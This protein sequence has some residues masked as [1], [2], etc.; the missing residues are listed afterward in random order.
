[1]KD[2]NIQI[3][4]A[5][6]VIGAGASAG[7]LYSQPILN[8]LNLNPQANS[9][10]ASF[11]SNKTVISLANQTQSPPL[12]QP[13]MTLMG[14]NQYA[15]LHF[16]M[17]VNYNGSYQY[18]NIRFI[19][20]VWN[21]TG[22]SL[23]D[24]SNIPIDNATQPNFN[25]NFTIKPSINQAIFPNSN[26][27]Q[28][29]IVPTESSSLTSGDI[30]GQ[31]QDQLIASYFIS[32]QNKTESKLVILNWNNN[33]H[34]FTP[35]TSNISLGLYYPT[36]IAINLRGYG[37]EQILIAGY[38]SLNDSYITM[39][40]INFS[41]DGNPVNNGSKLTIITDILNNIQTTPG[42]L[43]LEK[44][45]VY[46]Y[47]SQQFLIYGTAQDGLKFLSLYGYNL[48]TD[49]VSYLSTLQGPN[50][51]RPLLTSFFNNG[52]SQLVVPCLTVCNANINDPTYPNFKGGFI[53]A[54]DIFNNTLVKYALFPYVGVV[55]AGNIN[56]AGADQIAL[57]Q[58]NTLALFSFNNSYMLYN[59]ANN[60]Y[61][62][63]PVELNQQGQMLWSNL[64][65]GTYSSQVTMPVIVSDI[66]FDSI[67]E[68]LAPDYN[69]GGVRFYLVR[70][71]SN[72]KDN[73]V[74]GNSTSI[75]TG[76]NLIDSLYT[77]TTGTIASHGTGNFTYYDLSNARTS[78]DLFGQAL[79]LIH[80]DTYL[81]PSNP[82]I[83]AVLAAAPTVSGISQDPT[84]AVTQY[85]VSTSSGSTSEVS[86][87]FGFDL[88]AGI[89]T[90][91]EISYGLGVETLG[92]EISYMAKFGFGMTFSSSYEHTKT[93][94]VA[95]TWGT[96]G[97][98]N[99]VVFASLLIKH[100]NY[101][102]V[103]GPM[104][105][106]NLTFS[107]PLAVTIQKFDINT[108]DQLFPQYN[109]QTGT[110][111]PI[112]K[113]GHPETYPAKSQ[114]SSITAGSPF[115][116]ESPQKGV[117]QGTG[118]DTV[119]IDV[120]SETSV[121]NSVDFHTTAG[122][123]FEIATEGF[124]ASLEYQESAAFGHSF[125]VS[126]G[127]GT[128]Y[129]GQITDINYYSDW[130]HYQFNYGMFAYLEN[131]TAS[132]VPISYQVINYWV[133]PLGPSFGSGAL[134]VLQL[135]T[136]NIAYHSQLMAV[137]SIFRPK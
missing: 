82:T 124:Q 55:G 68:I 116:Y 117:S 98:H 122:F 53:Y 87:S 74:Y 50:I 127:K 14:G 7:V 49:A 129:Y 103:N 131:R 8:A 94:D 114:I 29:L 91:S 20:S 62:S 105:G 112:Q 34:T 79:R 41:P 80:Q 17:N 77:P 106:D 16:A 92:L 134:V 108:F 107:Y 95:Q 96:D 70:Q 25:T 3:F 66:T 36:A 99:G 120:A 75:S 21:F 90:K 110:F 123:S 76:S 59:Y 83:I 45:D 30:N 56:G 15:A 135:P 111:G 13:A 2:R 22:S 39:K 89:G 43:V 137:F 54:F 73:L 47:G 42:P 18:S 125:T 88:T 81:T 84:N 133:E 65:I 109:L 31:G 23:A 1:M 63:Y 104:N 27:S 11:F 37:A 100:W 128:S 57:I 136:P 4:L 115:I 46:G 28:G 102:V 86:T 126:Q 12:V 113:V 24:L 130:Q 97:Q 60:N 64:G 118:Y 6:V 58:T 10:P 85:G 78:G 32:V 71:D 44:G 26:N 93:V 69:T 40:V 19:G 5:I 101:T 38:A 9:P 61:N 121:T 48:T 35:W 72:G 132:G 51:G 119:S 33:T 67:P 52:I